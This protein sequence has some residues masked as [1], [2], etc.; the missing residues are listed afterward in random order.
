MMKKNPILLA[1]KFFSLKCGFGI[2]Y[3]I[4][5]KYWPIWVAVSVS[6]LNQ[7]IGFGRTLGWTLL[8][9]FKSFLVWFDLALSAN[10]RIYYL[11]SQIKSNLVP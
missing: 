2:G 9:S 11:F 4:G 5:Q 8:T 3:G 6:D 1:T 7:N 10:Y